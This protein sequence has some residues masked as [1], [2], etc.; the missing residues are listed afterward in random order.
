MQISI[1]EAFQSQKKIRKLLRICGKSKK[2][3]RSFKGLW[4]VVPKFK[5]AI[6]ITNFIIAKKKNTARKEYSLQIMLRMSEK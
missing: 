3:I 6:W 4:N 5:N 2:F 1:L